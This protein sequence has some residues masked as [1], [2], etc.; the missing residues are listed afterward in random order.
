MISLISQI[1]HRL[2]IIQIIF[3]KIFNL[4]RV[5]DNAGHFKSF[6]KIL[7]LIY[8]LSAKLISRPTSIP[9]AFR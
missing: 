2:Q 4:F 5:K 3:P 9:D 7:R 6:E 8:T 1:L